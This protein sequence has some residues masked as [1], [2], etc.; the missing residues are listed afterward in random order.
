MHRHLYV[1]FACM[2]VLWFTGV[3]PPFDVLV[4]YTAENM[5]VFGLGGSY[6]V[7]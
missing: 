2:P 7:W 6:Q 3:L 1:L 4:S 5:L